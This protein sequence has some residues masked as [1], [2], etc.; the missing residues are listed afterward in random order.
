MTRGRGR[1]RQ[2]TGADPGVQAIGGKSVAAGGDIGVAV[3]GDNSGVTVQLPAPEPAVPRQLPPAPADF[4]GRGAEL[5]D[6]LAQCSDETANRPPVVI[7]GLAGVGKSAL[8]LRLAHDLAARF[9]DGQLYGAMR[10]Q[11]GALTSELVLPGFLRALGKSPGD[12]PADPAEQAASFRSLL[13]GRRVLV[14]LDDVTSESQVRPLLPGGTSSLVIVTSRNPLPALAGA[15]VCHLGLL[16]PEESLELLG[17]IGGTARVAADPAAAQRIVE[18]C[19]RLPLAIRIAAAQLRARTDWTPG[20]LAERLSDVRSR[21]SRL[22]IHDLDVRTSFEL[23]YRDLPADA[24]RLFRRLAATPGPTFGT[25]LAAAL[26]GISAADA[27][28]LLGRLLLDRLIESA[29][30]PGRYRT[31]DLMRLLAIE[32]APKHGDDDP[33]LEAMFTWHRDKMNMV[34][35]SLFPGAVAGMSGVPSSPPPL[36][37][38]SRA[39]LDAEEDALI[40]LLGYSD[41]RGFDPYTVSMAYAVTVIAESRA[42]WAVWEKACE[43]GLAAARRLDDRNDQALLLERLGDYRVF[44][45]SDGDAATAAFT[46]AAELVDA[47]EAPGLACNI[48]YRLAQMYRLS[49]RPDDAEREIAAAQAIGAAMDDPIAGQVAD[50]FHA[51]ALVDRGRYRE[52]IDLLSPMTTVWEN[53]PSL[54]EVPLLTLLAKALTGA[55]RHADA[56]ERLERCRTLCRNDEVRAHAPRTLLMLGQAYRALDRDA[57]AQDA[58]EEGLLL[59]EKTQHVFNPGMAGRLAYELADLCS[60]REEHAAADEYF[61]LAAEC[62][63]HADQPFNRSGALDRQAREKLALDDPEAATAI[64]RTALAGL[65]DT[66]DEA[67]AEESRR[68]IKIELAAVARNRR[69]R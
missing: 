64:W 69:R 40:G 59:F 35:R 20:H 38:E 67:H 60:R 68:L 4:T 27:D 51:E 53:L 46:Q 19:G 37:A 24:A 25:D 63:G 8:A 62:F 17:A 26:M 57:D 29:D 23:S 43:F 21:L 56:A 11:D 30:E 5:R 47:A 32:L 58:W 6:L 42:M 39:W 65:H 12:V 7:S 22:R 16:D 13:A 54:Q 41:H 15:A 10:A 50:Q 31:H 14:I 66:G 3:T 49:G 36:P 52:A 18:A 28:D 34:L 48:H 61:A 9:P 1:R 44:R 45:E 33:A 55:G 2:G